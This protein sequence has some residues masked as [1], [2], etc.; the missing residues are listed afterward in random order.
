MK[1]GHGEVSSYLNKGVEQRWYLYS[2]G[3]ITSTW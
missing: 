2:K 3:V 1:L